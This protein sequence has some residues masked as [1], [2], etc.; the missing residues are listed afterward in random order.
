MQLSIK[1]ETQVPVSSEGTKKPLK[2]LYGKVIPP[3]M[4]PLDAKTAEKLNQ[5]V[6]R[7]EESAICFSDR[8][9]PMLESRAK[10]VFDFLEECAK[11]NPDGEWKIER[12][13]PQAAVISFSHADSIFTIAIR[14]ESPYSFMD[15]RETTGI[16]P[17]GTLDTIQCEHRVG[18]INTTSKPTEEFVAQLEYLASALM[19]RG[20]GTEKN[21]GF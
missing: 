13:N 10:L 6:K 7:F 18:G 19:R 17:K 15:V 1:A 16:N 12:R 8:D 3:L 9:K 2:G 5:A 20:T 4:K 14:G 21:S 11:E